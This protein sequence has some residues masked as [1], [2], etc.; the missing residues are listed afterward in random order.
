MP[1]ALLQ[2][3]QRLDSSRIAL[4]VR[5]AMT[6]QTARTFRVLRAITVTIFSFCAANPLSSAQRRDYGASVLVGS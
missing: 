3:Y 6:V 5:P 2:F 1:L 4:A